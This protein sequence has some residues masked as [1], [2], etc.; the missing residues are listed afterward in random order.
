[1]KSRE[2]EGIAM[3]YMAPNWWRSISNPG[4]LL[5]SLTYLPYL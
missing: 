1:M 4:T 3:S 2:V 5:L